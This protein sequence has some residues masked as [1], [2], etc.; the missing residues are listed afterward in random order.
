MLR[1]SSKH[2]GS[3]T[4]RTRAGST[5]PSAALGGPNYGS[6]AT[7]KKVQQLGC[8]VGAG[9]MNA[10]GEQDA[11]IARVASQRE[12]EKHP[13]AHPPPSP[14]R[15]GLGKAPL[16]QGRGA[17]ELVFVGPEWGAGVRGAGG[18]TATS[19]CWCTVQRHSQSAKSESSSFHSLLAVMRSN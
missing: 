13:R 12:R 17:W 8:L 4:C 2:G 14:T 6:W 11:A 16:R 18:S 5:L 10:E 3:Q 15:P 19:R 7:G 9:R 1:S